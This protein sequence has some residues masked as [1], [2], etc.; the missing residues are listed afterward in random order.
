MLRTSLAVL[1]V[2]TLPTC[3]DRGASKPG[4]TAPPP[5]ALG[6]DALLLAM[7]AEYEI[8]GTP[9]RKWIEGLGS[10]YW[11]PPKRIPFTTKG[12]QL[13]RAECA[14]AR[15]VRV[16]NPDGPHAFRAKAWSHGA[17]VLFYFRVEFT[18][19]REDGLTLFSPALCLKAPLAGKANNGF[20]WMGCDQFP[21]EAQ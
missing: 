7:S 10:D 19:D 6:C 11:P 3:V 13:D 16:Q 5:L 21:L 1:F 8:P 15:F 17:D 12:F 14:N 2:A 4:P 9:P 18:K 20:T